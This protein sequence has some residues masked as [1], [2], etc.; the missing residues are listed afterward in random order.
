MTNFSDI[1]KNRFLEE[2]SAISVSDAL[3]AIA[4]AFALSL[5]IVFVY[6][7]TYSGVSYNKNFANCLIMLSMV[8]A[9]VILVISSNVVLSLGMVGALSIVRFRTAIKEPTD[10]AFMFWAIATGIIC[11]A[12]YV[13]LAVLMTLLLGMLFVGI[14]VLR[15]QEKKNS[16]MV[17]LR[18]TAECKIEDV[19]A[20]L[21]R[22]Q[23]KNKNITA[24][25]M[26]WV[27]EMELSE[28][29]IAKM[30]E[31]REKP[32]VRESPSCSLSA[33]ACCNRQI[34]KEERTQ[35]LIAFSLFSLLKKY[36]AHYHFISTV[37]PPA[38]I[39]KFSNAVFAACSVCTVQGITSSPALTVAVAKPFFVF[40]LTA[41]SMGDGPRRSNCIPCSSA[42]QFDTLPV[43]AKIPFSSARLHRPTSPGRK[44][45]SVTTEKR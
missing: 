39:S 17:V 27:A 41:A 26:E 6:R 34:N 44:I 18:Y 7:A 5:F 16:Y 40:N 25:S 12:G 22:Y 9:V 43:A 2:F 38:G 37:A 42:L 45:G 13:T 32:G 11:G 28:K 20:A 3:V 19:L 31:L 35:L 1:I 14:H 30:D 15:K 21:P 23:L 10:T 33:A 24:D 4:L 29:D 36:A 8:T